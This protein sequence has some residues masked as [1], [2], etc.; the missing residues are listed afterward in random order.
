MIETYMPVM[1]AA[2]VN[3]RYIKTEENAEKLSAVIAF[4]LLV[5]GLNVPNWFY[6]FLREFRHSLHEKEVK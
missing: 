2:L 1:I 3:V 6:K 4:T 5:Y